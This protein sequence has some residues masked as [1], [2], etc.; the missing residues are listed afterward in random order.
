MS[1]K[2]KERERRKKEKALE[3]NKEKEEGN[4]KSKLGQNVLSLEIYTKPYPQTKATKQCFTNCIED[5]LN[6]MVVL[7]TVLFGMIIPLSVLGGFIYAAILIFKDAQSKYKYAETFTTEGQCILYDIYQWELNCNN[8]KCNG[9]NCPVCSPGT[10]YD[11]LW[12]IHNFKE[13]L[14]YSN[15]TLEETFSSGDRY[16]INQTVPCFSNPTCDKVYLDRDA[17]DDYASSEGSALYSGGVVAVLIGIC[18]CG[19]A[20]FGVFMLVG[21]VL[22]DLVWDNPFFCNVCRYITGKDKKE[23]RYNKWN[24]KMTVHQRYDYFI[25]YYL[26]KCNLKISH[27]I[28]Q[29]LYEFGDNKEEYEIYK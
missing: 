19:S 12:K 8:Y 1:W 24:E 15:Y 3:T 6:S 23:Y 29:L 11:Y 13:C 20:G 5:T 10:R 7:C 17:M 14:N 27:E 28:S 21:K 26:R 22:E 25:S 9:Q 2:L 16:E 18:C 4:V